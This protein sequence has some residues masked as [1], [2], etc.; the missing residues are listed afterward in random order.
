MKTLTQYYVINILLLL[1]GIGLI[2]TG[3]ILIN[4]QSAFFI[5]MISGFLGVA[6]TFMSVTLLVDLQKIRK[7]YKS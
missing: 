6:C 4:N 1:V 3:L 7:L 2:I 5:S